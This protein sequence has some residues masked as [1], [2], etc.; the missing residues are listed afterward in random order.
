MDLTNK[1]RL[2]PCGALIGLGLGLP[3]RKYITLCG[4]QDELSAQVI[5]YF[6]EARDSRCVPSGDIR[7]DD[8]LT[9][10][11]RCIIPYEEPA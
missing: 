3:E 10:P 4:F 6:Q 5:R 11:T 9:L 8:D 7:T 1:I 2:G